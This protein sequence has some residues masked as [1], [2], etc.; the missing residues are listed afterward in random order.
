M[1]TTVLNYPDANA[2]P[3][4]D[5]MREDVKV[6]IITLAIV[7][8]MYLLLQNRYWVPGGDSE[9]YTTIARN[10]ATGNGYTFNGE[11]VSMVPP[12]WSTVMAAAMKISPTFLLLKLLTMSCMLGSLA[13]MYWICRRFASP[14]MCAIVIVL[15]GFL[16]HVYSL[17]FWLHSDALFCLI[18]SAALLLAFQITEGKPARWRMVILILLCMAAVTVRWAGLL[19]WLLVAAVLL[20]GELRPRLSDRWVRAFVTGLI[21]LLTFLTLRQVLTVSLETQQKIKEFGGT[22][23]DPGTAIADKT[24]AVSYQWINPAAGGMRGYIA[25][26]GLWGNWFAQLL[27]QPLRL[28]SASGLLNTFSLLVGWIA[29]GMLL[30]RA[31]LTAQHKHWF[32]LS[33]VIYSLG[34]GLNWPHPA[35][36]YLVPIAPL[37]LLAIFMGLE[38]LP[39]LFPRTLLKK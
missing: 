32:W 7:L 9:V 27:W 2:K 15:T 19:T 21:T 16:S 36:R 37:I 4:A 18:S 12:G 26:V 31:W 14:K 20:E 8:V 35:A 39:K 6:W 33:L 28:S 3:Q 29:L 11:P 23:D 25:R 34:L 13:I 5:A 38:D 10:L 17:T 24:L 1:T 22:G 30:L